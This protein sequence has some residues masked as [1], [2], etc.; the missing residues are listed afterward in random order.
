MAYEKPNLQTKLLRHVFNIFFNIFVPS[1]IESNI[2]PGYH[3]DH[4]IVTLTLKFNY[5]KKGH[6]LWKFNSSLLSDK[7]FLDTIND[8][9][10]KTVLDYSI[11]VYNHTYINPST[12]E[13]IEFTINDQLF[14]ETLLSNTIGKTISYSS[15]KKK[16]TKIKEKITYRRNNRP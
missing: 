13:N 6:G 15:Y 7:K 11:P 14:L 1:L 12:Y 3:T 2:L 5:F 10:H 4:S 9:I 8:I 16:Q